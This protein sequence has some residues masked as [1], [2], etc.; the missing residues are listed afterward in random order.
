MPVRGEP[1]PFAFG[2]VA[3]DGTP[4]T[5]GPVSGFITADNGT[6]AALAGPI[7][8]EG[9]G[10]WSLTISAD[11]TEADQIALAF[12][13]T[14]AVPQYFTIFLEPAPSAFPGLVLPSAGD[15]FCS[16]A[17]VASAA[18]G[19]FAELLPR[20]DTL[21]AG[22]DGRIVSGDR[23]LL[24][25][26]ANSNDFAA[27]GIAADN[28]VVLDSAT[29]GLAVPRDNK[30][31]VLAV[32]A[33]EGNAL[34]L[35]RLAHELSGYGLPP[36]TTSGATGIVFRIPTAREHIGRV[37]RRL[38]ERYRILLGDVKDLYLA[39]SRQP[40][41]INRDAYIGKFLQ[42][43]DELNELLCEIGSTYNDSTRLAVGRLPEPVP[44][45]LRFEANPWR[46]F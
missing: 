4:Y 6:Q 40:G 46:R 35:R 10:Q 13:A 2:M 26:T 21:A 36:A 43:R 1:L 33:R 8:H 29:S 3:T 42:Y 23:W 45:P 14:G 22:S 27:Q 44:D 24:T 9:N 15:F 39:Q 19:D 37:S 20:L 17:D 11:E 28:V 38:A 18:A 32:Y 5:T 7:V 31:D 25:L 16:D 41:Q 30:R 12:T 34:R